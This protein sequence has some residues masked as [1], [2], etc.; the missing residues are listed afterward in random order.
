[1]ITGY[2]LAVLH[3]FALAIGMGS[4]YA[5]WRSL[6]R[7]RSDTGLPAVFEADNWYGLAALLWLATGLW[8][9]FGDVAKPTEYY[10]RSHT[11][12]TKMGAFTLV[13]ALELLPMVTLIRWRRAQARG[14]P[15]DL[16]KAPLLARLT[17][18]ELVLLALMV[19][20]AA[21]MARGW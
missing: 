21:A 3:L 7:L 14:A 11:F 17:L 16:S 19:F 13:F 18:A 2:L 12:L 5:R 1:M 9:A 15:I 8:R 4:V 6:R 20:L 10:L